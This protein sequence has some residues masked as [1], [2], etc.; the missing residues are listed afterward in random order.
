MIYKELK[1]KDIYLVSS[2]LKRVVNDVRMRNLTRSIQKYGLLFP[3]I[4]RPRQ[5]G[6]YELLAGKRRLYACKMLG[7]E[8]IPALIKEDVTEEEKFAI[9]LAENL[10]RADLTP[11]EMARAFN[12]I[13]EKVGSEKEGAEVLTVSK[14]FMKFYLALLNLSPKFQRMLEEKYY[15]TVVD[16]LSC[17]GSKFFS[18]ENQKKIWEHIIGFNPWL[19]IE[20]IKECDEELEDLEAI[21]DSKIATFFKVRTCEGLQTCPHVPELL[22]DLLNNLIELSKVK[23]KFDLAL[24]AWIKEMES[25]KE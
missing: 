2:D 7:W 15:L 24:A 12:E 16:S 11:M 5:D 1:I 21:C 20:I 3:V 19:Q 8:K 22:R 4:V 6:R 14:N 25:K 13:K 9:S 17:L 10:Q 23:R 18:A